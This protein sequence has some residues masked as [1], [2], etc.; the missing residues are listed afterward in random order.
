MVFRLKSATKITMRPPVSVRS[1]SS[2]FLKRLA[3]LLACMGVGTL[4]GFVGSAVSGNTVWYLAVPAAVAAG[5]LFFAD[6]TQC[7]PSVQRGI[8]AAADRRDAP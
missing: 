7:E 2:S 4:V 1:P 6:P 3:W 5:W 8:N